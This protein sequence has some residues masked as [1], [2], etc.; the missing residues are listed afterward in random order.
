MSLLDISLGPFVI[1]GDGR[2]DILSCLCLLFNRTWIDDA[3]SSMR[4]N[5]ATD[6][7]LPVTTII[8]ENR[9]PFPDVRWIGR[10]M[11][12]RRRLYPDCQRQRSREV[13]NVML[14][15]DIPCKPFQGLS[16]SSVRTLSTAIS[17]AVAID[18]DR[19]SMMDVYCLVVLFGP[20]FVIQIL[21]T[22]GIRISLP[23]APVGNRRGLSDEMIP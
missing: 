5:F 17:D 1:G 2:V 16:N 11:M 21:E 10:N 23:V 19:W 12:I 13:G 3:R 14:S 18:R 4:A 8:M 22:K 15:L 9:M 7:A 20:N 6:L